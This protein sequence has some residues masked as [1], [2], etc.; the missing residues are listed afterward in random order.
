MSAY[1]YAIENLINN[2]KYIGQTKDPKKRKCSHFSKLRNNKHINKH[3]Q[4]AFNI[5]GEK[6]FEFK[7]LIECEENEANYLEEKLINIWGEYN[8]DK[9]VGY[10]NNTEEMNKIRSD[11]HLG[12]P[13]GNRKLNKQQVLYILSILDFVDNVKRPLGKILNLSKDPI[14]SLDERKTYKEI[15]EEYDSFSFEEK[16]NIFRNALYDFKFNPYLIKNGSSCPILWNSWRVYKEKTQKSYP[17]MSIIF[18]KTK[19]MIQKGVRRVINE[20]IHCK[21][22]DEELW[23]ILNIIINN[24]TVLSLENQE[25]CND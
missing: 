21:Y 7:I 13:S 23:I 11:V 10:Y 9:K 6:N 19:D 3:L 16:I 18:Y 14:I 1:I 5:Y 17:Q 25:K 22:S 15:T 12:L 2:K 4:A 8:F 20:K 24:N